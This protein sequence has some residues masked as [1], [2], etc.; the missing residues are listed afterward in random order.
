MGPLAAAP[1]EF[2][3]RLEPTGD[4]PAERVPGDDDR[5]RHRGRLKE[6]MKVI[7]RPSRP[8]RPTGGSLHPVPARSYTYTVVSA[9]SARWTRTHSRTLLARAGMMATGGDPVPDASRCP[10][11]ST[12]SPGGGKRRRSTRGLTAHIVSARRETHKRRASYPA[13]IL[14]PW[15]PMPGQLRCRVAGVATRR[16]FARG[17]LARRGCRASVPGVG[18]RGCG[19]R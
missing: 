11:I 3:D 6:R 8:S 17:R 13:P 5:Q 9:A 18:G 7:R 1:D 14:C 4:D 2:T 19:V 15:F 12:S 10:P 16:S